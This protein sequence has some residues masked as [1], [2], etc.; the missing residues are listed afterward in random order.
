MRL[1]PLTRCVLVVLP[2]LLCAGRLHATRSRTPAGLTQ[3]VNRCLTLV[4]VASSRR[5]GE[6]G[7][8]DRRRPGA[9]D[10]QSAPPA[11]ERSPVP[12]E[13]SA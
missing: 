7:Q 5:R 11:R 10:V 12:L 9:A 2:L 3:E 6:R 8:T 13:K 4:R 1:S